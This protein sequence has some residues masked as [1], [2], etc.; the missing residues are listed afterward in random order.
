[1]LS[2]TS[3]SLDE[4]SVLTGHNDLMR[5]FMVCVMAA[6]AV[7]LGTSATVGSQPALAAGVTDVVDTAVTVG[8]ERGAPHPPMAGRV[9]GL[10]TSVDDFYFESLDSDFYLGRN[11]AGNSTLRTVETIVAV[12]PDIDQNRGIQGA[13]PN[14]YNDQPLDL[15]I[16]SIKDG[17]GIPL[18]HNVDKEEDGE[19]TVVTITDRDFG[20]VHGA[21]TYVIEY[22]Q[23]NVTLQ[24]DDATVEEFFW[25]VNG[26]GARQPFERVTA[27][28]HLEADLAAAFSG[29]ASCYQGHSRS[30]D[31]CDELTTAETEDGLLITAEATGLKA[32]QTL[33][34]AL[35]F[36]EGT[37]VPRDNSYLASP[38]AVGQL[39]M[40]GVLI[41]TALFALFKRR[42]T[43]W[44][45]PGRG[46]IIP[47]YL[48]PKQI[49]PLFAST[50]YG[51]SGKAMA[52]EFL[53]L[54]VNHNVR[55]IEEPPYSGR[56]KPTFHFEYVTDDGLTDP[57]V[58]LVSVLFGTQRTPGDRKNMSRPDPR[59]ARA[60]PELVT[61]AKE[62]ALTLGYRHKATGR[63]RTWI[64]VVGAAATVLS[65]LFGMAVPDD[66]PGALLSTLVIMVA[67]V[68]LVCLIMLVVGVRPITA[69]G[70]ELR[71]YL[72]GLEMYI[73][74]A[75][76]D[77]MRVLQSPEGA[78][79]G[80]FR[81]I[82][83]TP[84]STP[85]A[86]SM[87]T[88]AETTAETTVETGQIVKLYE[89]LLPY[90]VLFG[91][92]KQWF[93]E[94]G[95]VYE[96]TGTRPDWYHGQGAF[97]SAVF[98]AGVAGLTDT[99]TKSWSGTS[100]SSSSS[101]STGGG[102]AGGGGGGGGFGGV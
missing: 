47:E 70:A 30:R 91:L 99:A 75:E 23:T 4:K 73:R 32:R 45:D 35:G 37:F 83:E 81:P 66:G 11:D 69:F 2:A 10:T 95:E 9:D 40:L 92:E 3:V 24:P 67:V 7:L 76:A 31:A 88:T 25:N 38:A 34:V 85:S 29:S 20:Y 71:D 72:K 43:W 13:I 56:G 100:S 80:P 59:M 27:R 61:K 84:W 39:I 57:G 74:L 5:R 18:S 60:M 6:L 14:K 19:F 82:G 50:V 63:G 22:H 44:D 33:T 89:R 17:A 93:K 16:Y 68:V 62:L 28:V 48:P 49:T 42:T 90:A 96:Q 8:L 101:G 15:Q 41:A 36:H 46:T 78:V 52:A 94:L 98:A 12:F 55:V 26:T 1:M 53:N 51:K 79:R 77:R 58:E 86:S 65:V 21:K 97:S 87:G 54:A 102:H 64:F